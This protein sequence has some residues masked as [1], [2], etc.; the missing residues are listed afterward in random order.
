MTNP[1]IFAIA[2]EPDEKKIIQRWFK[3]LKLKTGKTRA[4]ILREALQD[5]NMKFDDRGNLA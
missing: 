4:Q 5:Y 3:H 2:L 1:A